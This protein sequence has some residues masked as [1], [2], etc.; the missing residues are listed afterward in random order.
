ML[1]TTKRVDIALERTSIFTSLGKSVE[2]IKSIIEDR[3]PLQMIYH[4][5]ADGLASIALIRSI[6]D[7]EESSKFPYSPEIF[8]AYK[9]GDL[10]VDIGQPLFREY[11]G[12]VIDHHDHPNPWYP[13]IWSSVPT[14]LI[15]YKVFKDKIPEDKLFLVVLSCQGDG[16]PELIPDEIWDKLWD[17]LWEHRGSLYK[18]RYGRGLNVYSY[19]LFSLVASPVNSLCRTG[20]ITDAYKLVTRARNIHDIVDSALGETERQAVQEEESR[21]LDPR[22]PLKIQ[23]VDDVFGLVMFRSRYNIGSRIAASILSKNPYLTVLALNLTTNS[24]SIRGILAKYV[25]NKLKKLGFHAGGHA[26]YCGG[27]LLKGQ[28]PDHLL[29]ALRKIRRV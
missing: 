12:V 29:E 11:S 13:L 21:T 3:Q 20:H 22:S 10:A 8:G 4:D 2:E 23:V 24:I 18:E 19:P 14:G 5:D 1:Q 17:T 15:I 9:E 25:A 16:Q 28:T 6:F 7:V 26:G 27:V